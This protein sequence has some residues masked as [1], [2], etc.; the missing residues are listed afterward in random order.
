MV[1]WFLNWESR[2][3]IYQCLIISWRT[4]INCNINDISDVASWYDNSRS[5]IS[6][7]ELT[8]T[9]SPYSTSRIVGPKVDR[10]FDDKDIKVAIGVGKRIA[11][12]T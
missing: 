9:E 7:P 3:S 2:W 11:E 10:P 12:I 4:R 8:E 5:S 1:E 6:I